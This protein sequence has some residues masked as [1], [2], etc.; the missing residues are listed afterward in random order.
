[1]HCI[2]LANKISM[3]VFTNH[4]CEGMIEFELLLHSF[5]LCF[6]HVTTMALSLSIISSLACLEYEYRVPQ[7]VSVIV[8]KDIYSVAVLVKLKLTTMI[9]RIRIVKY[10]AYGNKVDRL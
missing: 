3:S 7:A 9:L 2:F 4:G 8:D 6:L 10:D 5:H 1:M